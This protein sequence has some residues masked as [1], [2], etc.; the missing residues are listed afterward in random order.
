MVLESLG[1]HP[2]LELDEGLW[3]WMRGCPFQ[4]IIQHMWNFQFV[5]IIDF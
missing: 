1:V 3:R 5:D 4:F 2:D